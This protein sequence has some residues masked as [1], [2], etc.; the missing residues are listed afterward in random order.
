M[1]EEALNEEDTIRDRWIADVPHA[2]G[3]ELRT[4][5]QNAALPSLTD[6]SKGL[7]ILTSGADLPAVIPCMTAHNSRSCWWSIQL[8]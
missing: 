6:D 7:V 1:S 3:D 8:C 4:A 5:L 2:P